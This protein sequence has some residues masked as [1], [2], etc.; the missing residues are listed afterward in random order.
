RGNVEVEQGSD[1][2]A[3]R[4]ARWDVGKGI[5]ATHNA[6]HVGQRTYCEQGGVCR[7]WWYGGP[8]EVML[9]LRE[10]C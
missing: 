10:E 6:N 4:M 9:T 2:A 8:R 1:E 3:N 7:Q 5:A